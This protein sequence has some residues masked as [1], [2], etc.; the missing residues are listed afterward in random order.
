MTAP[1]IMSHNF[2]YTK[3]PGGV[4][5]VAH[6]LS[7]A[8]R[9]GLPHFSEAFPSTSHPN[10]KV[11]RRFSEEISLELKHFRKDVILFFPNYF[12]LPLPGSSTRNVVLVHDLQYRAYPHFHSAPKRLL[13]ECS[14]RIARR[15]AA[16]I[17]FISQ[18]TQTD[19]VRVFGE[20]ACHKV[21][22][23]PVIVDR[24]PVDSAIKKAIGSSPYAIAN[25]HSYP[26]KNIDKA[27]AMFSQMRRRIPDLKLVLTGRHS[28][29]DPLLRSHGLSKEVIISTGFI[30]KRMVLQLVADAE[31]FISLSLFEGF[32]MAAAEAAKL[33]RPLILSDIPV[34]RELFR[35]Y[36]LLVDPD[37]AHFPWEQFQAYL[38]DFKLKPRWEF[39]E[40]TEPE[41]VA[42]N[43]KHFFEKVS[44]G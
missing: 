15:R 4:A 21:I 33:G 17:V 1:V 2:A 9:A 19:F 43:Y 20:P 6:N 12:T 30:P 14:Y 28:Q 26:H 35:N 38:S 27:F 10:A 34:H 16:G 31:L 39:F 3:N 22:F 13:L 37:V 32:N 44:V 8:F 29:I 18:S 25:F 41:V 40:A 7:E 23:N 42:R 24:S 5:D 11:L 36:A